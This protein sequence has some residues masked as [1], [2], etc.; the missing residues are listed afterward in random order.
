ME[1]SLALP[2]CTALWLLLPADLGHQN[3]DAMH[4]FFCGTRLFA[5]NE[6]FLNKVDPQ[7]Q[8]VYSDV[9]L[10]IPI[11]AVRLLY[12]QHTACR[13]RLLVRNHRIESGSASG[14]GS[15]HV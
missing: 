1:T 10:E 7:I 15:F 13:M 2:W 4:E 12:Q 8:I 3:F 5:E 9:V 11:Q 6:I 14:L